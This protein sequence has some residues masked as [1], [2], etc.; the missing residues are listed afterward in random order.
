MP[1]K[2]VWV[3][4]AILLDDGTTDSYQVNINDGPVVVR[5]EQQG[6]QIPRHLLHD[7]EYLHNLLVPTKV[8]VQ[9]RARR[10]GPEA[11]HGSSFRIPERQKEI[12][13]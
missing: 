1:G 10:W 4:V 11:G 7:P 8:L 2:P 9:G 12:G 6:T 3:G 13:T 5:I